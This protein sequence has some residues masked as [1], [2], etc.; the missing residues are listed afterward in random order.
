MLEGLFNNLCITVLAICGLSI[1]LLDNNFNKT[2]VKGEIQSFP[3]EDNCA[4][5]YIPIN[6]H[7][8]YTNVSGRYGKRG[9]IE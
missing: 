2:F 6:A 4:C 7:A 1:R 9:R 8:E 5:V 3:H